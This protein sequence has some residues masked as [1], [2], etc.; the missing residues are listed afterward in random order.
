MTASSWQQ[1]RIYR[2]YHMQIMNTCPIPNLNEYSNNLCR[3][4]QLS[5][6]S[7]VIFQKKPEIRFF[8]NVKYDF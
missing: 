7:S 8:F 3:L 5:V 6:T 4:A 1:K 2:D